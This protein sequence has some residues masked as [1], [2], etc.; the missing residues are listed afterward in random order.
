VRDLKRKRGYKNNLYLKNQEGQTIMISWN[1]YEK[2]F[3]D[4]RRFIDRDDS[5]GTREN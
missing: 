1:E 3:I 4:V 2:D 5:N